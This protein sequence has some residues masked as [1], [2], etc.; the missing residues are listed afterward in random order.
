MKEKSTNNFQQVFTRLHLTPTTTITMTKRIT[1]TRRTAMTN[2][3]SDSSGQF[4][5]CPENTVV[6]FQYQQSKENT[7]KINLHILTY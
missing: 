4:L 6:L 7:L 5:A 2:A 1:G 3:I